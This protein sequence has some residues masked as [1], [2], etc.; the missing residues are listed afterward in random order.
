MLTQVLPVGIICRHSAAVNIETHYH[1]A[2]ES[3]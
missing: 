2:S 3:R 1:L